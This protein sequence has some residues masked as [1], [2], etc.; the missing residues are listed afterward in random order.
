MGL[1][2]MV[3]PAPNA[4][5][6]WE[7]LRDFLQA[8]QIPLQLR[9]IDNQL[10]FPDESP[11]ADWTEL[12]FSSASGMMT[13]RRDVDSLRLVIWGNADPSLV[14]AWRIVAW[15][16]ATLTEGLIDEEAKSRT[17]ADF[18]QLHLLEVDDRQILS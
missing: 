11:P 17:A 7:S 5:I 2:L 13:L 6:T 9:M 18:K 3:R 8:R 10:A 15:A 14:Q 16:C 1:E 4:P 12:R